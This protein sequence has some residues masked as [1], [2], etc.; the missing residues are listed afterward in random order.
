M[1]FLNPACHLTLCSQWEN[2]FKWQLV[3]RYLPFLGT[4]HLRAVQLLRQA[5]EGVAADSTRAITCVTS[6]Q[7]VVPFTLA[8][9]YTK[10]IL[11][12]GTKDQMSEVASD[13]MAAFNESLESNTWLDQQ[14]II[15]SIE[16]VLMFSI[17]RKIFD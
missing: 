8:R 7:A 10:Y 16:K 3:F 6:L 15:A 12:S 1:L 11:P 4:T 14:T 2:Y 9:L 5:T 13:I 17:I